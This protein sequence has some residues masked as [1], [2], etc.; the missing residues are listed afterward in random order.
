M[1]VLAVGAHYDD[2]ELGCS[3]TLIKHAQN[4]DSVT[5]LVITDSAY[6]NPDGIQIRDGAVARREGEAAAKIIGAELICLDYQT[7]EVP[8]DD[9][10]G[11]V[12]LNYIEKLEIDTIYS[13]WVYDLHR[14]HQ[15]AGK[16]TLMA[17]RHVPRFLMYRSNFYDTE[18]RFKGN[19]YSDITAVM[20]IKIDVIKAHKSE[21]KRV[22]YKWLDFFTKMHAN[23]GQMIGVQYAECFEVVRYLV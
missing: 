21:L 13:H 2:I 7:F 10:L 15:Y 11:K 5:M 17:G 19:F 16:S 22:R 4:H 12:I 14:D 6:K 9:I 8:F 3:G 1:K 23:D 20:E 18:Q